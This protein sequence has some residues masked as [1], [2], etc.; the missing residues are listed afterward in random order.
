MADFFRIH[1]SDGRTEELPATRS[2]ILDGLEFVADQPEMSAEMTV[3]SVELA[4]D[5][6]P[7]SIQFGLEAFFM[8][9]GDAGTWSVLYDDE[10]ARFQLEFVATQFAGEC[11]R[12]P[13]VFK[14]D[15]ERKGMRAQRCR[16]RTPLHQLGVKMA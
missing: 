4:S 1:M 5:V 10:D 8:M 14:F 7:R 9:E 11:A 15:H 16:W 3:E 13:L 6:L 12:P 2:R